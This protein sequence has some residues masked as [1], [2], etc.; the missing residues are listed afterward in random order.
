MS[1]RRAPAAALAAA[2]GLA[3]A[4]PAAAQPDLSDLGR[5]YFLSRTIEGASK[6]SEALSETP[7]TATVITREEIERYGFRTVA[8]VLRFAVPGYT[9]STDRTWD[10]AGGRGYSFFED[11]N[12][13][14]LVMLDGHP[15][16]EPWN[17]FSGIGRE[18]LVPLELVERIEVVQGPSSLLYGGYSLYGMVNVVTRGGEGLPGARASVSAG[19]WNTWEVSGSYG[20]SGLI[21]GPD[22]DS[23]GTTWSVLGAAGYYRS[24]GEDLDLPRIEV[25][26]PVDPEGGTT[27]GGP[28]SGTDF[29]RAPFG[30]LKASRGTLTLLARSGY[31][32]HGEVFGKYGAIYG[33]PDSVRRD[34][35]HA[36]EL[37]WKPKLA[38][39]LEASFRA[40]GDRYEYSSQ[41]PYASGGYYPGVDTFLYELDAG[42]WDVG[43]EAGFTWRRGVHLVTGGVEYRYRTVKDS[44]RDVA[45]DTGEP[46]APPVEREMSGHLLVAYLQEEWRPVNRLSFVAG[47]TLADTRPGASRVLPRFAVIYKP[48]RRV[49]IKGLY[50]FGFR[51]PS[52]YEAEN[53]APGVALG[54]EEMR[55]AELSL[56]WDVAPGVA[57]QAYAFDS[58]LSGLIQY[59][60]TVGEGGYRS[61]DDVPSRGAG[62]SFQGRAGNLHGYL[63]AAYGKALRERPGT[64]DADLPGSSTWLASGGV[65]YDVGDVTGSVVGR[66]VGSQELDPA[67]YETGTAGDFFEANLRLQWKTR[68]ALYPLTLTLDVRNLFDSQGT[69][70]ASPAQVL[71]YVPIPGR[72]ALVSCEVRF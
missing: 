67:F 22:E 33:S 8:D 38:P 49:A 54:P 27:W 52:L 14:I 3:L 46:L 9:A 70:A 16:N 50:G 71:S 43:G 53:Q 51:P 69:V 1:A 65:S 10:Y 28:Q 68:L 34:T 21:P 29:E 55:S 26:Y 37:R 40:F 35:K 36:L 24:A 20:A 41:T 31:R 32:D 12:T 45:P 62:L 2:L 13:R 61:L 56:L 11:F 64:P 39:G 72:S 7:A 18:M 30:F 58:R 6:H 17:N 25:G 23:P 59:D 48:H 19:S 66:Y 5:D 4:G 63:N 42:T 44:Y 47:V 57:V 60:A 15:M